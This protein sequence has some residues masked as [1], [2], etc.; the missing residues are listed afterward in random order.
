[1]PAP[2]NCLVGTL[3]DLLNL[4]HD[5]MMILNLIP[6]GSFKR[7][8][9]V[10]AL[11]DSWEWLSATTIVDHC[12]FFPDPLLFSSPLESELGNYWL[13][14]PPAT[15]DQLLSSHEDRIISDSG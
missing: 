5:D 6:L 13:C 2:N 12:S 11:V 8:A 15:P 10:G 4:E 7:R 9:P 14:M 1:V 3:H